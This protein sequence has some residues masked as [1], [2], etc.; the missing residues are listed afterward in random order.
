[1]RLLAPAK[2]NLDLR[3]GPRDPSGFHPLRSW[4]CTAGLFDQLSLHH[5]EDSE[6]RLSC[7]DP[8]L[9][10][11]PSN[12]VIRAA[13]ALRKYC[14]KPSGADIILKKDIPIG[15]GLGGGSSDA[16]RTLLGLNRLWELNLAIEQL[17][18]I[19]ADLGSDVPFFLH[20][21]SSI[22]TGRGELVQPI[23]PPSA[24]WALLIYP[25]IS[26]STAHVYRTFD[27][28]R[29]GDLDFAATGLAED[30]A[31]LAA[32]QLLP[33]I[34]NALEPAAFA[35]S[36][37]LGQLRDSLEQTLGRVIR[38][39]GS[40]STLFT[41]FDQGHQAET[42]VQIVRAQYSLRTVDAELAPRIDDD[43]IAPSTST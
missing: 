35:I 5:R 11:G 8:D 10:A 18:E 6:I 19:A 9:P 22:C 39:T 30:W 34:R 20:G 27:E 4:F 23:P 40:G 28:L 14:P 26:L 31:L 12:L 17:H 29:L 37:Q 36:P 21:P 32:D 1:M 43:L 42:A 33:Q 25:G 7:D 38:M 24:K 2:I 3:V 13:N 41:L 15:G 16:A